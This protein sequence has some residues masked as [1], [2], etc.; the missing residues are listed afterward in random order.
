LATLRALIQLDA[1]M[2]PTGDPIHANGWRKLLILLFVRARYQR[3][4]QRIWKP[5]SSILSI[6]GVCIK[7]KPYATLAEAHAIQFVAKNTSIP[8]PKIYCAFIHDGETYIAMSKIK[9][10]MAWYGWPNRTKESRGRIVDQLRGFMA[11]LRSV[12]PPEGVGVANVLGGPFYDCRLPEPLNGP[13]S[14]VHEFHRALANGADFNADTSKLA[15]DLQ[16]LFSFYRQSDHELVLTHG[17]LSSLNTL[18]RGDEVVG[19]IDWETAGWF[20]S[21]WEYSSAKN[22]NYYNVLWADEADQYLNP[23]PHELEMDR[24]R[25]KYFS[26]M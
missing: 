17:D 10:Q 16:E 7:V 25:R 15:P 1:N 26:S 19:I 22:P 2:Q 5:P 6:F 3:F 8:V 20:P 11:E 24:I 23:M 21:Y 12:P 9:G 13:F 4:L 14:T 18:V